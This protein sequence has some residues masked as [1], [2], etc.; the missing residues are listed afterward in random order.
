MKQ[1]QQVALFDLG[2]ATKQSTLDGKSVRLFSS[3]KSDDLVALK[4]RTMSEIRTDLKAQ[5]LKGNELSNSV[6]TLFFEGL[7]VASVQAKGVEAAFEDAGAKVTGQRVSVSKAGT[8]R[9]TSV[10]S[11]YCY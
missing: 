6:R 3:T 9:L 8:V 4:I 5:G 10:R 7:G 1:I 11:S 2:T